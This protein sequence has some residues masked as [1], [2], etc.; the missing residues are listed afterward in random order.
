MIQLK[1]QYTSQ[2]EGTEVFLVEEVLSSHSGVTM[3]YINQISSLS[4]GNN[5]NSNLT[6]F[7]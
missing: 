7:Y 6:F 2:P 1:K 3:I 5:F 4:L